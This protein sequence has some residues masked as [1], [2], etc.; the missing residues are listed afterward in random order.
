MVREKIPRSEKSQELHFE[1]AKN[2]SLWKNSGNSEILRVHMYFSRLFLR[3]KILCTFYG[4]ESCCI[5]RIMFIKLNDKL[6]FGISR[7][8]I[9]FARCGF[10]TI[11]SCTLQLSCWNQVG[12][13]DVF[14]GSCRAFSCDGVPKQW[15]RGHVGVANE[16]WGSTFL[17]TLS[18]V[19]I[20]LYRCWS[21]GWKCPKSLHISKKCY[22]GIFRKEI[23]F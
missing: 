1:P 17:L 6:M 12:W 5:G 7:K 11:N 22:T 15:K 13:L 19:P 10:R 18:F 9:L 21:C 8:S 14:E 4:H 23:A 3:C 2:L 20:N 16:S